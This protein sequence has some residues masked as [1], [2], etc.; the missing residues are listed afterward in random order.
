MVKLRYAML[1][2]CFETFMHSL[3][4]SFAVNTRIDAQQVTA[5][6]YTFYQEYYCELFSKDLPLE[7]ALLKAQQTLANAM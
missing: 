5:A 6:E 7:Q 4:N 3:H 2:F 1:F